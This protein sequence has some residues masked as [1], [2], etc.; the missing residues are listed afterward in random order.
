MICRCDPTVACWDDAG[1]V[2]IVKDSSKL[3]KTH[4]PRYFDHSNFSSFARQLNFY[5]FRKIN[6]VQDGFASSHVR[7]HH[8]FFCRERPELLSKIKRSTLG[9]TNS[10]L[11]NKEIEALKFTVSNLEEKIAKMSSDFEV[12]MREMYDMMQQ[13]RQCNCSCGTTKESVKQNEEIPTTKEM[14]SSPEPIRPPELPLTKR[15]KLIDNVNS[16]NKRDYESMPVSDITRIPSPKETNFERQQSVQS[17]DIIASLINDG[18]F[19]PDCVD[20]PFSSHEPD[21]L[22]S[23]PDRSSSTA[24]NLL[25]PLPDSLT[26][27]P[28]IGIIRFLSD[29]SA[30]RVT[31]L[32]DKEKKVSD[33]STVA[34][35]S[36]S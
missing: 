25:P 36:R 12:K 9:N 18:T 11:V 23:F 32:G 33:M 10:K 4:I 19:D 26:R 27:M 28:E 7:F 30:S 6:N 1:D 34:V 29:L 5:G 24:S 14:K 8:E 17:V 35:T 2:F 3:A 20:M 16:I 22:L 31:S 21:Q 13:Q 15:V